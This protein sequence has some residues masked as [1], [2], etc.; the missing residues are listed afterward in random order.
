[1]LPAALQEP[2]V[3]QTP[4]PTLLYVSCATVRRCAGRM[5]MIK[6]GGAGC[7]AGGETPNPNQGRGRLP[8]GEKEVGSLYALPNRDSDCHHLDNSSCPAC[9]T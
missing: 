3:Q 9:S 5:V 6:V 2:I 1:M 4:A 8:R 7:C